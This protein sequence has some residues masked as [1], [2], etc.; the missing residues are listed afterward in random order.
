MPSLYMLN[1]L[2]QH[3]TKWNVTVNVDKTKIVVFRKSGR[4]KQ[5]SCRKYDNEVIDIV[6][7]FNYL[8]ITLN[9]NGSFNKTQNVLASQY[10]KK[11]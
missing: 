10:K 7:N 1:C 9:F 11:V 4:I 3:T 6:D 2:Y 8:G 5:N